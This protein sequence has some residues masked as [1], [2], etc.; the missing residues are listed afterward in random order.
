MIIILVLL[1]LIC[2]HWA[3]APFRRD[4]KPNQTHVRYEHKHEHNHVHI[5]HSFNTTLKER[6][7]HDRP[8]KESPDITSTKRW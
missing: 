8:K 5:E 1:F 4:D 6:D 2:L 7:R 3:L